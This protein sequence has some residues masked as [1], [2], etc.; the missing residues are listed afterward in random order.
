MSEKHNFDA[1]LRSKKGRVS[2]SGYASDSP[3]LHPD[4]YISGS[5]ISDFMINISTTLIITSGE[6]FRNEK[7]IPH[8]FI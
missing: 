2:D 7:M 8:L 6:S 1:T 5:L 4:G 3:I